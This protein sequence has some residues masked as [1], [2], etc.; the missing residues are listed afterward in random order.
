MR[1]KQ[2]TNTSKDRRPVSRVPHGNIWR[3]NPDY[4][5][6]EET[7]ISNISKASKDDDEK[8]NAIYKYDIHSEG[9]QDE[10]VNQYTNG[11]YLF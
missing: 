7:Q 5:D 9:K 10:Y 3:R 4:K 1:R 8:N 2:N 6:W 11:R